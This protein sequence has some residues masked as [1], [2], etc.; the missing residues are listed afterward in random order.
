MREKQKRKNE[1]E[2]ERREGSRVG[3]RKGRTFSL[4]KVREVLKEQ[5]KE[6]IRGKKRIGYLRKG[7]GSNEGI[8]GTGRKDEGG[9]NK[10]ES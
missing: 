2:R 9:K 4:V 8:R 6:K 5:G 7:D 3:R 1:Y 10:R